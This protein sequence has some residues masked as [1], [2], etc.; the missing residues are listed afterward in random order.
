MNKTMKLLITYDGS[1]CADAALTDLQ[2][3]GLPN[4]IE[5]VV[6]SIADVWLP[7]RPDASGSSFPEQR[8]V[9]VSEQIRAVRAV[10]KAHSLAVQARRRIQAEF[11]AW[12]VRHETCAD[13]PAWAA[14]KKAWEWRPDLVVVGSRD[15]STLARFIHGSVSQTVVTEAQCSVRVARGCAGQHGSPARILIGLDG[16]PSGADVVEA[17][18]ARY[19]PAE[20]ELRVIAVLDHGLLSATS[21]FLPNIARSMRKSYEA[22]KAWMHQLAKAAARKLE[23][24]GLT[25]SFSV[26]EGA[27]KQVLIEEAG[28]G[29]VD[30]IFVGARGVNGFKRLFLSSVSTAVA[31]RARCSVEV[32]Y[33]GDRPE[34]GLQLND[35]RGVDQESHTQDITD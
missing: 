34:S 4:K 8:P 20:S 13:S 31:L 7:P 35:L 33:P 25:V 12:E 2:Q 10:T 27:P 29:E 21:L 15:H 16:S 22:D 9:W 24:A 14:V 11:P 17:V 32:V 5:A 26:R 3:A 30:C 23:A 19:W 1:P 18:A 6:L 28:R